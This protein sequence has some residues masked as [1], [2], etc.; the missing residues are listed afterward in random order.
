M[1]Y[2]ALIASLPYLP[3]FTK[4]ERLPI[5]QERMLAR[6]RG[7][8]TDEDQKD[9]ERCINYL[10]WQRQP[11]DRS[12]LDIVT[13]YEA[14]CSEIDNPILIEMIKGRMSDRTIKAAFR[15]RIKDQKPAPG[16]KWGVGPWV[17]HI[18]RHWN[19]PD[20]RLSM[21]EPWVVQLKEG[22]ENDDALGVEKLIMERTWNRVDTLVRD[23]E[24]RLEAVLAYIFKWEIMQRWLSFDSS[25]AKERFQELLEEASDGYF[26]HSAG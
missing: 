3:H 9:L 12:D 10:A 5:S 22:L 18:E 7:M 2:Y 4:V 1:Q 23:R 20:F 19:E 15:R 14:I 25:A 21:L 6:L 8:L 16:E 17:E 26:E 24:F 13:D 11:M